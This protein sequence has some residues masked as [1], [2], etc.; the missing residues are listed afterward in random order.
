[1][2]K[3]A[4]PALACAGTLILGGCA[5]DDPHQKAKTGA[6]IG[7][8][9][10]GVIGHQIDGGSGKWVGAAVGALA[11]GSVGYY[12]DTQQREFEQALAAEQANH[13]LEIERLRDETL[14][15]TVDNEVSFDFDKADI[16]PSFSSSLDKL[17]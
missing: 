11:G 12:M 9:A 14:K 17:V 2:N 8:I 5:T 7:A 6:L 3:L 13:A 1:M 15:L 16:R 4:L 10:G